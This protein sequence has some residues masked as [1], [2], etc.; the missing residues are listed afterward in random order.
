MSN[1][2]ELFRGRG[3]PE[4]GQNFGECK[5]KSMED[6]WDE[7]HKN[8]SCQMI[9]K[10]RRRGIISARLLPVGLYLPSDDRRTGGACT[11]L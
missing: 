8:C 7:R 2:K 5:A 10:R 11:V 3:D 9:T 6:Y 4:T 1:A